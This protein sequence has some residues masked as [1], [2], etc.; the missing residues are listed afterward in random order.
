MG[1]SANV[2]TAKRAL[3]E[4]DFVMEENGEL[5]FSD[6]VMALWLKRSN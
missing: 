3:M 6:P 5:K 2:V 4:K 1:T